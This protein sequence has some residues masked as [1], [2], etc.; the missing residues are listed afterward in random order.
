MFGSSDGGDSQLAQNIIQWRLSRR[1][2][3]LP[4]SENMSLWRDTRV[5]FGET[6]LH[7]VSLTQLNPILLTPLPNH[8]SFIATHAAT[9][10]SRQPWVLFLIYTGIYPEP[11]EH[12]F[13]SGV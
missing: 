8:P 1:E 11:I 13:L 9:S 12:C 6:E 2:N 4:G 3:N 10:C 5:N 7:V